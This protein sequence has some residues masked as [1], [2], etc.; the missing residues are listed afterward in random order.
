M[1]PAVL[2]GLV[3]ALENPTA[4]IVDADA[5]DYARVMAITEPYLGKIVGAYS[6]GNPL[7]GRGTLFPE[8]VDVTCPWQF[9]NFRVAWA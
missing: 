2:G 9:Q 5:L 7:V 6:A 8:D 3:W 1:T 4:G